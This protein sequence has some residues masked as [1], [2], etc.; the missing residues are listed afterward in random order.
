MNKLPA[1]LSSIAR[2]ELH[3][4]CE[5]GVSQ[6]FGGGESLVGIQSQAALEEIDK[7]VELPDLG[8]IQAA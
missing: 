4:V 3:P 7:V 1:H 5:E 6:S 2:G 8:V